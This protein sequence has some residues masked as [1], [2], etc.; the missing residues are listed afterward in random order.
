[1]TT[2]R[3]L[4]Y[5]DHR[6]VDRFTGWVSVGSGIGTDDDGSTDNIP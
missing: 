2:G 1:M 5:P 4:T 3:Q 6:R